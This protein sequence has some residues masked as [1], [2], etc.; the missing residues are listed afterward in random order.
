MCGKHKPAKRGRDCGADCRVSKNHKVYMDSVGLGEKMVTTGSKSNPVY[1]L[2]LHQSESTGGEK[3]IGGRKVW[4][5]CYFL[6]KKKKEVCICTSNLIESPCAAFISAKSHVSYG[7]II[8]SV[9][10]GLSVVLSCCPT[11]SFWSCPTLSATIGNPA[12][13]KGLLGA[14]L[15]PDPHRP[16]PSSQPEQ[17]HKLLS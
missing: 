12:A 1:W 5:S 8:N 15:L 4:I 17:S 6:L 10:G 2:T 13:L 3:P 7:Q 9:F 14:G 11:P 16:Q